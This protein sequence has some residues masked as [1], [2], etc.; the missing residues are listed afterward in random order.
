MPEIVE[1]KK[2]TDKLKKEYRDKKINKI[3]IINGRYKNHGP[4]NHFNNLQNSL[5]L[6]ITDVKSKGKFIYFILENN[7]SIGMTLG[8]SG[9]FM[10]S[11]KLDI[12]D[13]TPET[14]ANITLHINISFDIDNTTAYFYDPL[15]YG[16]MTIFTNEKELNDKLKKIGDD[17]LDNKTTYDIFYSRLT[18][19]KNME[20]AICVVLM[21]QTVISG[22]GNY[23]R[24]EILWLAQINPFEK[25]GKL[26]K[27]D[28]NE[29]Y[30]AAKK[31]TWNLYNY[32]RGIKLGYIKNSDK[33]PED[34]DRDFF[35]YKQD[36]DIF[37][38]KIKQKKIKD[39]LV[40]YV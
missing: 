30:I 31:I 14:Q 11:D 17:I 20:K 2:Y 37:N 21:D 10:N 22:I 13:K 4:P 34:Y 8:L 38:N 25:V 36:K 7:Y 15:S 16:T 3:T 1:I 33:F 39:R 19:S 9:G 27:D 26:T 23:L 18:K 40:Y 35:V 29:I 12:I 24:S 32:K 6:K 5:P 28:I